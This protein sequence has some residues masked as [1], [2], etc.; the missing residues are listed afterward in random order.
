MFKDL[1]VP[2][3]WTVGV[4][5]K[6]EGFGISGK[7]RNKEGW[8]DQCLIKTDAPYLGGEREDRIYSPYFWSDGL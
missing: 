2:I 8:W 6:V 5:S 7:L 4:H 3:F 1:G